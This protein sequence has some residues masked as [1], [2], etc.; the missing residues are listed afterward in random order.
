MSKRRTYRIKK[1]VFA[2]SP[3]A[4]VSWR[5][6]AFQLVLLGELAVREDG[7]ELARRLRDSI[8]EVTGSHFDGTMSNWRQI[9]DSHRDRLAAVR[10]AVPEFFDG[11]NWAIFSLF[12]LGIPDEN[13]AMAEPSSE[14]TQRIL[15]ILRAMSSPRSVLSTRVK[16][17]S[18]LLTNGDDFLVRVRKLFRA[19]D[20]S[21]ASAIRARWLGL[22]A[23]S[24]EVDSGFIVAM[25]DFGAEL[26][27]V[28]TVYVSP[29]RRP[30]P[31]EGLREIHEALDGLYVSF[32]ASLG[33]PLNADM[34]DVM[35]GSMLRVKHLVSRILEASSEDDG[36]LAEIVLRSL[37][38]SAIQLTWL[39]VKDTPGYFTQ[40]KERSLATE[41]EALEGVRAELVKDGMLAEQAWDIIKSEYAGLSSRT[42]H[43][44]ELL[45][46]VYGP[47]SN[48][49]TSAMARDINDSMLL[50]TFQR[51]SDAAHGSW[52]SIEKYQLTECENPLH[53]PHYM[54]ASEERRSAGIVPV[55]GALLIQS[56][57]LLNATHKVGASATIVECA[58]D[59]HEKLLKWIA[60][61]QTKLGLF[62][63]E[64]IPEEDRGTNG[65]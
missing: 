22:R 49:S 53:V 17:L 37:S 8:A 1:S 24:P 56:N 12:S 44:P 62:E 31:M 42:G 5:D 40:F 21:T 54:P 2:G 26:P 35:A 15:S 28:G 64:T 19:P 14:Q 61:H 25:L 11:C 39:L 29:N 13:G 65:G 34:S 3:I 27:C 48:M 18:L 41:R 63:W 52:R 51:E 6:W 55:L 36:L 30:W 20:T 38:D 58:T 46:V 47:W 4:K 33:A 10:A 59:E 60:T 57:L 23:L 7:V 43:W 9:H 45:D 50:V 16:A 32:L